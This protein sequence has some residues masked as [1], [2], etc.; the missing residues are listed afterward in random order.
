MKEEFIDGIDYI[1]LDNQLFK[2]IDKRSIN[3]SLANRYQKVITLPV[4]NVRKAE[5]QSIVETYLEGFLECKNQA[6]PGD[7]IIT[8]A[9]GEEYVLTKSNFESLY[10]LA[11]N[12]YEYESKCI[13]AAHELSENTALWA[14]WNAWQVTKAGGFIVQRVDNID[15]IY[16]IER[17]AFQL[18]YQKI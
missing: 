18:T 14:P 13:V 10:S 16:L 3:F 8:G 4:V 1:N 6:K 17:N 2:K 11:E 15:D 5:E 9:V 12:G 7:Y